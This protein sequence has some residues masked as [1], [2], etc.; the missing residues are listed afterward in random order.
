MSRAPLPIKIVHKILALVLIP[1]FFNGLLFFWLN[2]ALARKAQMVETERTQSKYLEDL[3]HGL[4]LFYDVAAKLFEYELTSDPVAKEVGLGEMKEL[5]ALAARMRMDA[6]LSS[7]RKDDVESIGALME[8]EFFDLPPDEA[9]IDKSEVAS[10]I[11]R[12]TQAKRM[13]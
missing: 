8:Q 6:Q 12:V 3:N 7:Q 9:R 2:G 5:K 11:G 13:L 4:Q 1:F 10:F